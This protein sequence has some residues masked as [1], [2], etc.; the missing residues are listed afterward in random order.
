MGISLVM[1]IIISG[2]I[3]LF[4]ALAGVALGCWWMIAQ[5]GNWI[6]IL[7]ASLL[8]TGA[9]ILAVSLVVGARFAK[10]LYRSKHTEMKTVFDALRRIEDRLATIE[11]RAVSQN[12]GEIRDI[13]ESV[14]EISDFSTFLANAMDVLRHARYQDERGNK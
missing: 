5:D 1:S 3:G 7:A 2:G 12:A 9:I 11:N 8:V 14:E 4:L 10:R 13:R 6:S